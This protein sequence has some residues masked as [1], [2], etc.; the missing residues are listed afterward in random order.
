M[1]D[2]SKLR[3]WYAH[4]QGLDGSLDGKSSAQVLQRAGWARS[5]GGVSPYLTLFSR[6]GISREQADADAATLKIYELPSARGC[7][8]VL[9]LEDFALGLAAGRGF[10]GEMKTA[11]KLGVTEKEIDKLCEAVVGALEKGPL[12]PDGLREAAGKAVRNLGPEGKKKGL[13]TTLPVALGIL[14]ESGDIRR[15]PT[16]GRFDQQRYQYALWRPNP[17]RG[18]KLRPEQVHAELARKYFGWIGPASIA[19]FQTFSGLGVKVTKAALEVLKLEPIDIAPGDQ[20]FFLPEDRSRFDAFKPPKDPRYSLLGGIDSL[21]ILR[22]ENLKSQVPAGTLAN[23]STHVIVDRGRLVGLWEYDLPTESIAWVSFSKKD[24]AIQ[25]AVTRTE[26]FVREQ[27]GDARSFGLD[28][29]TS[30]GPRIAALRKA[31]ASA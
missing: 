4:R 9:P 27:L 11:A 13:T 5:V 1:V 19:D 3:A 2:A 30:R 29:P 20:R 24:K 17:L 18:F 22:S 10:D 6:A 8:Y 25:E 12:D 16:N 23:L 31:A 7:T 26:D 14:Q 21:L 28:S 15:V